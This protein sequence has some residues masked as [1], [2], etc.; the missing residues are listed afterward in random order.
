[1]PLALDNGRSAYSIHQELVKLGLPVKL[2]WVERCLAAYFSRF[3]GV[4]R[5][6]GN[7]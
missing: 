5:L 4:S 1:M 6:R 3:A 7:P 2:A